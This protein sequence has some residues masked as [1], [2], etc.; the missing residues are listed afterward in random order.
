MKKILI[1]FIGIFLVGQVVIA[2]SHDDIIEKQLAAY[3]DR[4]LERFISLFSDHVE[5]FNF[6]GEKILEGKEQMRERYKIRFES[7]NLHAEVVSRTYLG[8]YVIDH[9][10]V[11]GIRDEV[12]EASVI[13]HISDGLIDRMWFIIK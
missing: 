11:S 4:D 8:D 10:R 12:V 7:P 2:Q 3:N 6:P 9:E 13:Y 5:L 1:P